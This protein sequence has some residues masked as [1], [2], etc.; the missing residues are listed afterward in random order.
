V[1]VRRQAPRGLH[2]RLVG[3]DLLPQSS[4]VCSIFYE[5]LRVVLI[6]LGSEAA[7]ENHLDDQ[8]VAIVGETD[9]DAEVDLP[10]RIHVEV[11]HSE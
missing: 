1:S 4:S 5:W 3:K 11:D 6:S 7:P 10:T 2:Q 9:A 8:S